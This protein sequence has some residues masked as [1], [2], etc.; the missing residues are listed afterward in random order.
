MNLI[1]DPIVHDTD[2]G[3]LE[4]NTGFELVTVDVS[5]GDDEDDEWDEQE[6]YEKRVRRFEGIAL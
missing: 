5:D 2:D 4:L 6:D 3:E 1:G